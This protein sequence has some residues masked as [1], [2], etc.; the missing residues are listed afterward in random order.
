MQQRSQWLM[1]SC[2]DPRLVKFHAV[3]FIKMKFNVEPILIGNGILDLVK[4]QNPRDKEFVLE[5]IGI[6]VTVHKIKKI[7]LYNHFDCGY[8]RLRGIEYP[9]MIVEL[10]E[11][12][13][14]LYLA[15]RIISGHFNKEL[16]IS[17]YLVRPTAK[18]EWEKVKV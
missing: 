8:Y 3:E 6:A 11:L 5:K 4:P 10:L 17:L 2:Q 13:N 15:E 14:D 7:R 18:G 12:K 9:D 1:V 16:D